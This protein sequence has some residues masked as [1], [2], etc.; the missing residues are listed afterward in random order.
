MAPD[1][2]VQRIQRE[3]LAA[4]PYREGQ[5]DGAGVAARERVADDR[6]DRRQARA[7]GQAQ[8]WAGGILRQA[9]VAIGSVQ[10]DRRAGLRPVEPAARLAMLVTRDEELEQTIR[11]QTL[12]IR[13]TG[14]R[15]G[16][17]LATPGVFSSTCMRRESGSGPPRHAITR[18]RTEALTAS[19]ASTVPRASIGTGGASSDCTMAFLVGS[20]GWA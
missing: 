12:T 15:R 2:P 16:A 13:R 1:E 10:I 18:R 14:D 5:L 7:A 20:R 6:E 17:G 4:I 11:R 3:R 19:A 9:E 8:Q